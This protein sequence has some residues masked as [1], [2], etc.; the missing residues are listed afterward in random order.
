M[1]P[2]TSFPLHLRPLQDRSYQEGMGRYII[3]I[4]LAYFLN[5]CFCRPHKPFQDSPLLNSPPEAPLKNTPKGLHADAINAARPQISY[6]AI[7]PMVRVYN[8]K[9]PYTAHLRTLVPT[10]IAGIG[11]GTRVPKWAVDGLLG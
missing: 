1:V 6:H 4:Y 2:Y 9:G 7:V 5:P 3:L 10:T 8:P 11:F